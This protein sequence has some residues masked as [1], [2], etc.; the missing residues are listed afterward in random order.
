MLSVVSTPRCLAESR[1]RMGWRAHWQAMGKPSSDELKK[2]EMVEKFKKMHPEM[3]FSNVS[4]DS[5]LRS[6]ANATGQDRLMHFLTASAFG[7]R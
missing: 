3:D 5:S 6:C 1:Q 2:L 4:V 7:L